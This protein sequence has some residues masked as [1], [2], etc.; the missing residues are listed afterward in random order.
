ME[1][2]FALTCCIQGCVATKA[3]KMDKPIRKGHWADMFQDFRYEQWVGDHLATHGQR[4][5]PKLRH[6]L[7]QLPRSDMRLFEGEV[8]SL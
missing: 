5:W 2:D 1:S 4:Q 6:I 3:D 8:Q 7:Q